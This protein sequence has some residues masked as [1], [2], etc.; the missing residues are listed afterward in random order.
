M[1]ASTSSLIGTNR[2]HSEVEIRGVLHDR[3]FGTAFRDRDIAQL[4]TAHLTFMDFDLRDEAWEW[5]DI[6]WMKKADQW[7]RQGVDLQ[8]RF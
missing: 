1:Q 6:A 5:D 7:R 2:V 8:L 3:R 4:K